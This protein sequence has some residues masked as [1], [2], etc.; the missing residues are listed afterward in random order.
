MLRLKEVRA[1]P[2]WQL[3]PAQKLARRARR[4]RERTTI[5]PKEA[6]YWPQEPTKTIDDAH[7]FY[8]SQEW[9]SCRKQ[10]LSGKKF[11]CTDCQIDLSGN[12]FKNL[13]VDHIK[14][15]RFFWD[16][17]VE[18]SN[19]RIVCADCNRFKGN[20]YEDDE[21]IIRDGLIRRKRSAPEPNKI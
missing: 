5:D 17:R 18:E 11:V 4:A 21:W 12:N 13:N 16:L 15:L 2:W 3:T 8:E 6:Q 9:K 14:P 10:F 7:D 1:K 19:L 20:S